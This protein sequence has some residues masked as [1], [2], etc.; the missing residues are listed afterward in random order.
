MRVDVRLA[1]AGDAG[2]MADIHADS[3]E[4][5]WSKSEIEDLLQGDANSGWVIGR[6]SDIY[7]FAILMH[8]GDD[9]EILTIAT[10]PNHK[11]AGYAKKLLCTCDQALVSDC[12]AQD[13]TEKRW[14]L[15]VAIDNVAA[16]GLYESLGFGRIGRRKNYYTKPNGVCVDALVFSAKLGKLDH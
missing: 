5:N 12:N 7:A 10:A 9:I 16:I 2:V 1:N 6:E 13:T 11:R 15:E 4:K 3:F 8:S 14:L